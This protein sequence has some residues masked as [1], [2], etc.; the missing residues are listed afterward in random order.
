MFHWNPIKDLI[1]E[2]TGKHVEKSAIFELSSYIEEEMKKVIQQSNV[3]LDKLND[4]KK[5]Q[6][7]YQKNRIDRDCI[8]NAIK[9]L[10]KGTVSPMASCNDV[11]QV[12]KRK[13]EDF[14]V[15]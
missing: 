11:R 7:L 10:N 9:T 8:K 15:A 5:I 12:K 3:E 13:K 4:L 6:G 2:I 1:H 14:E